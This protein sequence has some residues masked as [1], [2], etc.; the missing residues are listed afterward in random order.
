MCGIFG[1]VSTKKVES[2]GMTVRALKSLAHRGPDGEGFWNRTQG[3]PFVTLG[4]RR[5]AILDLSESAAQPMLSPDG[6]HCL[7][8]NGEIYNYQ[9][10][11]AQLETFGANFHS[12]GDTEVLLMAYQK[13]GKDCLERLN[14]M[15][16]FAIWDETLQELF[17]AR[18][19]FGEKPFFYCCSPEKG[20]FAFASEIKALVAAGLARAELNDSALRRYVRYG[21]LDGSEET[22]YRNVRRLMPGHA[23]RVR[24]KDDRLEVRNWRYWSLTKGEERNPIDL[25][26]ASEEFRELFED[27]VR[28]RLRADVPVGTSLS[29]GVD[30]SAVVC[31]IRRLGASGGQKTFSARMEE[32]SLDE[33]VYI[34]EVLLN[35]GVEGHDVI[36]SHEDLQEYFGTLCWHMEEPFPATSMFAQFLVMRLAQEHGVTVLLDG[37][38]ADELLAG[39]HGYFR[40]HYEDLLCSWSFAEFINEFRSYSDLR[41]GAVPMSWKGVFASFLPPSWNQALQNHRLEDR[42]FALWWNSSWL[43]E[44][45]RET[46][47]TQELPYRRRL[48]AA[49]LRDALGGELQALLRYGDRNSMA[50]SRELRQ[51]FLDHRLAEFAFRLPSECKIFRGFTKVVLRNAMRGIVPEMILNR[52]DKLGYQAPQ[53]KWLNGPLKQWVEERLEDIQP[54]FKGRVQSNPLEHFRSLGYPLN[55]WDD[56]R[57]LFRFLTLGECFSQM[58][59]NSATLTSESLALLN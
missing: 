50:A 14:G 39:Y 48:N 47:E 6:L 32:Q 18:D 44:A 55:E 38:G 56:A 7:I 5:L 41:S 1:V 31:T 43:N 16:S 57:S 21:V 8:F 37:Q 29:G 27:S 4:H 59:A 22:L 25:N 35:S 11:R 42:A 19:R 40:L 33:G 9:E 15:F 52:V 3:S 12:T 28:L 13:W 10:L 49:L 26:R 2:P 36:P 24:C 46:C 34:N 23:L 58:K 20:L 54:E 30:S 45:A 53:G 51:P 17:A